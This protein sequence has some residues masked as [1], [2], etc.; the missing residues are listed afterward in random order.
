MPIYEYR[1]QSCDEVSSFFVRSIGID[2]EPDCQ[3]CQ[4]NQMQRR[5][6]S[7]ALGKT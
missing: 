6:S 3:H 1:C 5:M 7:F 4:S 2:L